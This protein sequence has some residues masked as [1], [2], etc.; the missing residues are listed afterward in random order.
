MYGNVVEEMPKA[1]ETQEMSAIA[2]PEQTEEVYIV[3]ES[4]DDINTDVMEFET[5]SVKE[6]V[7]EWN[8]MRTMEE[9]KTNTNDVEK[10]EGAEM[11]NK[12]VGVNIKRLSACFEKPER[13][14]RGE[15]VGADILGSEF[16]IAD[17]SS[18]FPK[19]QNFSELLETKKSQTFEFRPRQQK[20]CVVRQD[21]F[22]LVQISTNGKRDREIESMTNLPGTKTM[23]KL[24]VSP[25]CTAD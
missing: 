18:K 13:E 20:L 3:T 16:K 9:G 8:N 12:R 17:N 5:R 23:K 14:G 24:K 2:K 1:L 25:I 21:G 11:M 22:S 4:E 10:E 15:G 19:F 7:E 6:M